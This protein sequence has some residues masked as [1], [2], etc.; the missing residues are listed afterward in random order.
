MY[1]HNNS[2][3][4][5]PILQLRKGSDAVPETFLLIFE[6][7]T[8]DKFQVPKVIKCTIVTAPRIDSFYS[9][10]PYKRRQ[11]VHATWW[12]PLLY[13]RV[14]TVSLPLVWIRVADRPAS[15]YSDGF[16]TEKS[17][18]INKFT[19]THTHYLDSPPSPNP[20]CGGGGRHEWFFF[21]F[22]FFF[23]SRL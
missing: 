6:Y 17:L 13:S 10:Q 22:F 8:R 5:F 12:N 3:T 19:H 23:N 1:N 16:D 2:N 11:H 4:Y 7:E 9:L 14:T 21:F 18:S 20:R 15:N